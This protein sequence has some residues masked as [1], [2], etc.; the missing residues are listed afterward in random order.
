MAEVTLRNAVREDV[1]E[2]LHL[3]TAYN[4]FY[5]REGAT[6]LPP[7]VTD[8]TW[9]RLLDPAEPMHA[10]VAECGD[11]LVAFAHYL[12]HRSTISMTHTCYLQDLFTEPSF[13]GKGL[14]TALINKVCDE[15]R[16]AGSTRVYW[17]THESNVDARRLYDAVAERSG[18]IIYRIVL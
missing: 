7:H 11:R 12:F 9:S 10:V 18:F 5:G 8:A 4:V 13:R 6:A 17:Q 1:D 15:A 3:W 14:A 2:W 16:E